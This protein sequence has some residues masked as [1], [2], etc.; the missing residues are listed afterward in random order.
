MIDNAAILVL[1]MSN[2]YV[3]DE[4]P[5]IPIETRGLLIENIKKILKFAHKKNVP[6]IYVN[7]AFRK[8]DP[9]YRLINYRHQGMEGDANNQVIEELKPQSNDYLLYK[10][11]YD[12]F[13]KSG[14]ERLLKKLK[15]RTLFLTGCQTD[16]CVRETA[17]TASHLG[18]DV[19]VV[20]DCCQTAREFG[21]MAALRFLTNCTRA[22][23]TVKELPKY[24][25]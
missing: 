16:C 5:L 14:L 9:I 25:K 20:K 11:G 21:Q 4:K 2:V 13:W 24:F 18:Y 8:S 10:R 12:G 22:L 17:V 23:P 19:Y 6:V 3:Y 7:S 1:D 15:I